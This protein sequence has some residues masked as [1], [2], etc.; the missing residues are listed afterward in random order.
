MEKIKLSFA[1]V[2]YNNS[3]I[4]HNTINNIL[5]NIPD[6]YIYKLYI[7][8]NDS[9]DNTVEIVKQI[10][11]NIEVSELKKNMGFAYGH[12]TII[13][14]IES[15]YHFVVNPDI[16][17]EDQDQIRKMIE[18]LENNENVGL[19]SPLILGE[20]FSIQYLCKTDP[21]VFDMFIRRISPNI[22]KQRQDKYTMKETG[23]DKIIKLEYATGSFMV[24]RTDSFKKLK[25][26]DDSFFM[27]L[28]DADIT[29]RLNQISTAVF[30]P[31]ARVIHT[32]ERSA[33][34]SIKYAIITLKSMATYFNKWG[35]KI[36]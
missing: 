5:R 24:F 11:G 16:T 34:K 21:T 2:T 25:G 22:F 30:F 27:Y 18:Y 3:K 17:I 7:I 26:F 36:I 31:H 33:H 20:D 15:K 35:W 28:E 6:D 32:W 8:D 19:L 14:N 23:Y 29:R 4:I 10:Q 9:K 1:I 12:N 13:N